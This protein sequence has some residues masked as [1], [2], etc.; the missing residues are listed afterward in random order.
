MIYNHII[1]VKTLEKDN[2]IILAAMLKIRYANL[3]FKSQQQILGK[4]IDKKEMKKKVELWE[5]Q[6]QEEKAKSHRERVREE[7]RIAI[8]ASKEQLNL[9]IVFKPKRI[10]WL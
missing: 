1:D 3:I 7:A 4:A 10:F 6:L 5:A 8:V 9:T 2:K